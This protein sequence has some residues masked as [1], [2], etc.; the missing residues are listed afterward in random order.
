VEKRRKIVAVVEDDPSTLTGIQRLLS[1]RGLG[2][3]VF[4]SAEA[5]LASSA[6]AR[7]T[8]LLL[9]IQLSGMS[10]FE[11]QRQLAASGS[12][13]PIIFMT[14]FDNEV[15][16]KCAVEAGCLAYLLKPFSARLL[17]DAI[18]KAPG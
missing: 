5:F 12:K 18:D 3:E 9:D 13:L 16:R 17:F 8:C 6:P 1:A 7:A 11:L 4:G 10:S 2:P 14:A 15:T